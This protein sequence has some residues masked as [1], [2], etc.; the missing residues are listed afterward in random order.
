MLLDDL[1]AEDPG[2]V[3]WTRR[4]FLE[5]S[6]LMA[7]GLVVRRPLLAQ[8]P[9]ASTPCRVDAPCGPLE[10]TQ[11]DGVRR[12][13]GV[14]FA[15]PPAGPLRFRAPQPMPRWTQ[16]RKA[17]RFAA[18]AVQPGATS[19]KQSE[20]CLYLNVWTP[21]KVSGPLP[22]LVWIHGGGFTGGAAFEPRFDGAEFAREGVVVVTIAYRLGAFGFLDVS[23]MLGSSYA[24][25]ANNGMKDVV[26]ALRWV[27]ENIAAFGGDPRRVTVGG[28]SAGA[29]MTDLLMGVPEARPYFHQMISESGGAE[30]I[31]PK[32][33]SLE[34]AEE[35]A[36]LW[37]KRGKPRAG[38]ASAAPDEIMDAQK[39][40][41]AETSVHFPL[42]AQLDGVFVKQLPVQ[43]IRAGASKGKRL[44]LGTNLEE[45]AS[46]LGP[47]PA[48]DPV[49]A[50]LGNMPLAAFRPIEAEY[51]RVYP[52]MPED[53]RRVR[54]VT[55][56]EYWIPSLRVAD[57]LVEGGGTAFVYLFAF[58]SPAGRYKGYAFHSMELGFVW[59]GPPA[60]ATGEE[61]VLSARMH[62]AWLAFV[63]G[64]VPAATG[65]PAWP[66]YDLSRR[67][68]MVLDASP[69]V[70][71]YPHR[72]EFALWKSFL[73]Q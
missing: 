17:D 6:S 38:L 54:S 3:N 50:D 66:K 11:A 71:E 62:A 58:P 63:N 20:D 25:S 24:G 29:K 56:E 23:P 68:T 40:F 60:Q 55:A 8:V 1:C 12:F 5:R 35:F 67:P 48:H 51:A 9:G 32:E 57:A 10:G 49:A 73:G 30:R 28:E 26:A 15:Q 61:R 59:N 46:F 37:Q 39:A 7:A 43:A 34:V 47:H 41:Y 27:H 45:S 64:E 72:E 13:F 31:F 69:R 52:E 18:A 70:E 42:R 22:V 53:E 36:R 33:R 44:L 21:A 65:L 4:S 14:P 2:A 19:W 16:V